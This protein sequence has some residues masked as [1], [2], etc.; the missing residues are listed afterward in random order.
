M[1]N[2]FGEQKT[3]KEVIRE[4]QRM[5][6]RSIRQLDR[7]RLGIQRQ[8]QKLIVDI[9][10]M[11]KDG[12]T[13]AVR[14]MAK[15]LVRIR[16][17]QE[18]FINLSSQLN[19]INLQMT[20][21]AST[22]ALTQSLRQVTRSMVALNKSVKLPQLQKIMM[23]FQKQTEKMNMQGEIIG[24]TIDDAMD[25]DEDEEESEQIVSQVLDEIGLDATTLFPDA[26]KA[27]VGA[28]EKKTVAKDIVPAGS[29]GK[30]GKSGK[31][32]GDDESSGG[33]GGGGSSGGSGGDDDADKELAA[34]LDNLKR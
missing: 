9:K 4:Q 12:Q 16:K 27:K 23:E 28:T 14:I 15:D 32:S 11:A 3:L 1:G 33:G 5:L 34:R 19:A 7:E 25:E 8:E 20:T 29:V 22:Q 13:K 26:G 10:K 2:V 30:T 6:K 24:D 18:K 21:M 31:P 17:H